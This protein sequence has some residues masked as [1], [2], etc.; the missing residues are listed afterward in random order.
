MAPDALSAVG[1]AVIMGIVGAC[2]FFQ[3][4]NV[5]DGWQKSKYYRTEL[6]GREP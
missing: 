4:A 5:A 3:G 2:G 6:D 1:P